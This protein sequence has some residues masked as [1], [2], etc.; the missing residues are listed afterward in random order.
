MKN[1][2]I[3]AL[4][5]LALAILFTVSGTLYTLEEGQQAVILEFGRTVGEP[6]DLMLEGKAIAQGEIVLINGKNLGVRIVA[7]SK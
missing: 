6:V 2:L 4:G 7:V 5:V 1:V 3:V